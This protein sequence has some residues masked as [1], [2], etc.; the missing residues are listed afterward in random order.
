MTFSEYDYFAP[1]TGR[2]KPDDKGW[3]RGNR[4]VVNVSWNDAAAYAKWLSEQLGGRYRLPSEAEW[5]YAARAGSTTPFS[6]GE[7]IDTDQANY[8]G[9]RGWLDCLKADVLRK[10][11]VEAGAL[12]AN[13][14]GLH[15]VHG[16]VL[17]WVEDC[18][19][20][21]YKNAPMDSSAWNANNGGACSRRV[22][23]GGSWRSGPEAL[24]SAY[25]EGEYV[26]RS[27]TSI[28]FRLAEDI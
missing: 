11:T 23:R 28:G 27:N 22:V 18:W 19:H 25:R 8:D 13:P 10:K 15:E 16:N 6:S 20:S 4:P 2:T 5:E 9:T 26:D 7:C 12:P 14:W 24:R 21:G 1:K 17:E 3:G